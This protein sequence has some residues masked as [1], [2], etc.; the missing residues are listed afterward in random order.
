MGGRILIETGRK[1]ILRIVAITYEEGNGILLQ[2]SY[3]ESPTD[4]GAWLQSGGSQRVRHD[5]AIE[6][7]QSFIRCLLDTVSSMLQILCYFILKT[8]W[9]QVLKLSPFYNQISWGSKVKLLAP[10]HTFVSRSWNDTCF[11]K[12]L[13]FFSLTRKR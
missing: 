8:L 4:R 3:L 1:P 12:G 13:G 10:V 5:W 6:P 11:T 2:Y 7:Q 9:E